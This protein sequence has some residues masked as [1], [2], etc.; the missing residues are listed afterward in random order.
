VLRDSSGVIMTGI[1]PGVPG[2]ALGPAYGD[3]IAR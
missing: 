2:P 1:S 3:C